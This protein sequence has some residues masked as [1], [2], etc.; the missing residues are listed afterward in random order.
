MVGHFLRELLNATHIQTYKS[1]D[2]FQNLKAFPWM[3]SIILGF[4]LTLSLILDHIDNL[5]NIQYR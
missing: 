4:S 1:V 3:L 2:L 5:C